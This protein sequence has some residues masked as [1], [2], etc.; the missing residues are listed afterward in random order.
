MKEEQ[1]EALE[2][3]T[4]HTRRIKTPGVKGGKYKGNPYIKFEK[5]KTEPRQ[6]IRQLLRA[7]V[8]LEELKEITNSHRISSSQ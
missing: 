8:P 5:V 6:R 2:E 3:R 1:L 7:S 4:A